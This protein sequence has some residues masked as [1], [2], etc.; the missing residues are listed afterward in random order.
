MYSLS[1]L[2]SHEENIKKSELDEKSLDK[3]EI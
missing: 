1:Y 2:I 3:I